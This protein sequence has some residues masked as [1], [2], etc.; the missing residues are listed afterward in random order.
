MRRPRRAL[1]RLGEGLADLAVVAIG[2][3]AAAGE[4]L[5]VRALLDTTGDRGVVWITHGTAG[6]D[7]MDRV[8]DLA[9]PTQ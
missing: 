6:L 4:E 9:A 8:V 5:V 1:D 2:I 7:R 3:E